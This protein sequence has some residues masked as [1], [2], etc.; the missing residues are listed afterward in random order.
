MA[1]Y[2]TKL[3]AIGRAKVAAAIANESAL[4]VTEMALGDGSGNPVP[5]PTG[6]ETGMVREVYRAPLNRF[7]RIPD[8]EEF[9]EAEMLVPAEFGGW[10]V[11]E[12]GLYDVDGDLIA[13]GNF[14][15]LYKATPAEGTAQ[16]LAFRTTIQVSVDADVT[17]LIDPNII[18]ATRAWVSNMV[19]SYLHVPPGGT[20]GQIVVKTGNGD[21]DYE[22][23]DPTQVNVVVNAIP[24]PQVLAEN[25]TVVTLAVVNTVGAAYYVDGIRLYPDDY[26]VD[27]PT[28]ITLATSY[29]EGTAFLAV[30]NEPNNQIKANQ[31]LMQPDIDSLSTV[32]ALLE[33]LNQGD[34]AGRIASYGGTVAPGGWIQC[35]GRELN[36]TTYARLFSA[37]GTTWGAG[38]GTTTFNVPDLTDD[39]L[40]GAGGEFDVGDSFASQNKSHTHGASSGTAGSHSHSGTTSTAGEHSHGVP[41][42]VSSASD[43]G[44]GMTSGSRYTDLVHAYSDSQFAGNHNH[45]LLISSAGSHSHDVTVD[46]EGGNKARPQGS[47]VMWIIRA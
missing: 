11:R 31:V 32:Q 19:E 4:E 16:D 33:R 10:T 21:G 7:E 34:P 14:P 47:A 28:Q 40:T 25:Q 23:Q 24:E 42:G 15:A 41:E 29:P 18:T 13:Y 8:L 43:N 17:L 12:I 30:Q 37:I 2:Y 20:L 27:S 44:I 1:A 6:N 35:D 9:V 3:T 39:F 38:N 46:A 26:T 36:R 5:E 45:N 22:W